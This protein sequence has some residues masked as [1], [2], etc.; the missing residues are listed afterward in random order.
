M[1]YNRTGRID[2]ALSRIGLGG[3]EYLADGRSRAFNEDSRLAVQPGYI[4][5]GFGQAGRRAVLAAA[6]EHGINFFDATVDSEKEALGRNLAEMPP[7]TDVYV[8]TRPEGMVY[9]YDPCNRQM[10]QFSLLQAE[11]LRGLQ[12]LRRDRLDFLNVAFMQ[13]ALDDDPGYMIKIADNVVRLKQEGLIRFACAD[14]FSGEHTYLRQIEQ[15][16]FDAIYI[17]LNLAD[18]CGRRE[19]LPAAR[20][21]GMGVFAR[22]AFMKGA[23]FQMG[24]QAGLADR[25]RLAQVALKWVLSIPEVTMVVVGIDHPAQLA[26]NLAVLD[27][28][29][30]AAEDREIVARLKATPTFK[31]Y[32]AR[33]RSQFG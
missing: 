11:V 5:E 32:A 1:I 28:P 4:F 30:L 14:T 13:A 23:L 3:H 27:D 6:Y 16:C 17:N 22:E 15:G 26:S 7:P 21:R 12:L 10:A 2:V 20:E 24:K 31:D 18:D 25:D 29:A 8:Q 9:S 19:V 33:K